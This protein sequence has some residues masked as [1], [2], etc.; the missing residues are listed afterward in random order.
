M[1]LPD[2]GPRPQPWFV[3]R[4]FGVGYRPLA[5]QGWAI[6]A[7][8]VAAAIVVLVSVHASGARI[9]VLLVLVA[10]Y[11]AVGWR[12][13]GERPDVADS[14]AVEAAPV[15]A[16]E[17]VERT[18]QQ[19]AAIAELRAEASMPV[20]PR[21]SAGDEAIWVE[22]LTKRFGE[23]TALAD[24]SFSV[25]W[26]EVFGFLG[27][28]GAG[29]T[30]AVRTLGTLIAPSAGSAV[31]AGL[32]LTPQNA[33]AIRSR[34][35]IMPEAPGLYPRLTVAENLE[36]FAGL[37]GLADVRPKIEQALA[38]VNLGERAGDPCGSLS[39]GLKQ[40]V[41]IAR[42]LLSDP[43]VLFLDEPTSGLDPVASREV[44]DLIAAL[45][46]RG[47][48]IFLTTHRLEEAERMCD[49]VAILN[50]SLRTVGRPDEL[51]ERLFA[52]SLAVTTAAP[53]EDPER[54]F[55]AVPGVE[56]WQA[57]NGGYELTAP[58]PTATAP[59]LTRALVAAGAD[60]VSIGE[61]RRSL[62]DV[63]LELIDE[64][65]EARRS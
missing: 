59:E 50:T 63:Y 1:P 37:Y 23:R 27:P 3:R 58:D 16:R 64:D 45:R 11:T 10:S 32:A 9:A 42:A 31:V 33:V 7:V 18:P 4:R 15:V 14:A 56:G 39:K 55:A 20:P 54:L 36:F 60:V 40:R 28:N 51:R 48:T 35:A 34:I 49:R 52:R 17:P 57:D 38:T 19:V 25:G 5:W 65:V 2:S 12:L 41:A 30:T 47:V 46:E 62:E 53:L 6:A 29:K 13:S 61:R 8:M 43:K 21:A 44:H 24:V 26:G 22:G